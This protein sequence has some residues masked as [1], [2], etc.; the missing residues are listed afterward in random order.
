MYGTK[1]FHGANVLIVHLYTISLCVGSLQHKLF[2]IYYESS[3]IDLASFFGQD[4]WID[5]GL[6]HFP[7]YGPRLCSTSSWNIK[8]NLSNIQPVRQ[9]A[10]TSE[11]RFLNTDFLLLSFRYFTLP[12]IL[13]E[14][15]R[16]IPHNPYDP[17]RKFCKVKSNSSKSIL[18]SENVLSHR[19]KFNF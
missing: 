11:S 6:V 7:V 2:R 5:I 9:V 1:R 4:W 16:R 14:L 12:S 17:A 8:K 13:K 3:F 15:R 18:L 19:I 10:L